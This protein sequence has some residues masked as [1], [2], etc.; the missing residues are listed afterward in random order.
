[1]Y[2]A[3]MANLTAWRYAFDMIPKTLG[4]PIWFN[5]D[6]IVWAFLYTQA[7]PEV[8]QMFMEYV[9]RPMGMGMNVVDFTET[10]G[11]LEGM[12]MGLGLGMGGS[13]EESGLTEG[14][15][16]SWVDNVRAWALE[17]EKKLARDEAEMR[18]EQG[19]M[20]RV[21]Q[22]VGEKVERLL[23]KEGQ[24]FPSEGEQEV[25]V[26]QAEV[27]ENVEEKEGLEANL[28]DGGDKS[29]ED[30]EVLDDSLLDKDLYLENLWVDDRQP[31]SI[32]DR[33]HESLWPL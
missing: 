15:K 19:V 17:R 12:S 4:T 13:G 33:A 16:K 5:L 9:T 29:A 8:L 11:F 22:P 30:L 21:R 25:V 31:L 10:V 2:L 24:Q 32:L 20:T 3:L 26:S 7:M 23:R 1:M 18:A 6:R 14:M 27:V 28:L